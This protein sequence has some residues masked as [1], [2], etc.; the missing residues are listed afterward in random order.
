MDCFTVTNE[1]NL[2]YRYIVHVGLSLFL[3]TFHRR[4][5]GGRRSKNS[6]A[7]KQLNYKYDSRPNTAPLKR[8]LSGSKLKPSASRPLAFED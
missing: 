3:I 2:K 7:M 6:G 1:A 8:G 5:T 4:F